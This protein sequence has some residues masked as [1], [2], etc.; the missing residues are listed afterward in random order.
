[1]NAKTLFEYLGEARH[2]VAAL[3]SVAPLIAGAADA[4]K[5]TPA[6]LV[7]ALHSAFGAHHVRAVH[8]KGVIL[9]G[10]FAPAPEARA[11]SSAALFAER[12]IPVTVRFSDFT[13]LPDIPDNIGDASP[14]GLAIKFHLP[15]GQESDVV[16]HSFNGF[17]VATSDEFAQLMRTIG[18]SGPD[19]AKPTAL[20]RFLGEHPIAKTFLTTQKPPPVSYGTLSYFGVNAFAFVDAQNKRSFVRYRFVPKAGEQLLDAASLKSK[21]PNYLSEEIATR[22]V[23]APVQF[24]WFAQVSAPGD[25]I[26]NPSVAWPESRRLVKLGTLTIERVAPEQTKTDK[27]LLFLPARVPAGIEVA[28]PMVAV[29]SAAYPISFGERQ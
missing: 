7:E 25:V 1:M 19:A 5:Q 13:G 18:A 27:A 2:F 16:T 4:P 3:A 26:D 23:S 10:R 21:G 17:P 8:S 11:L 22:V 15:G 6:Q 9:E 29:R 24:D 20:D 28:D 14:R 12:L